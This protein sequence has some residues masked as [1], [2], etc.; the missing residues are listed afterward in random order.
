[1]A[2]HCGQDGNNMA[3]RN[4]WP[5]L[6]VIPPFVEGAVGADEEA[7]LW[8]WCFC[9]GIGDVST[10]DQEILRGGNCVEHAS[11]S[12]INAIRICLRQYSYLT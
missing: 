1:M 3:R 11:T 6:V 9:K 12:L 4:G 5:F 7:L 8:W 2:L 10:V